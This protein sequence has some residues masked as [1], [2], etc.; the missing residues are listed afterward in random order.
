MSKIKEFLKKAL[1]GFL[2]KWGL[3][4]VNLLVLI[5]AYMALPSN[6]WAGVFV[7]LW[8]FLLLAYYIFWKLF[9]AEK[10]LKGDEE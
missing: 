10:L 1:A 3:Q 8:L 9:G 7:G 4:L 6:S 2:R 5:V